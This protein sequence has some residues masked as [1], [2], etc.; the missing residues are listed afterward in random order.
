MSLEVMP[1]ARISGGTKVPVGRE[2]HWSLIGPRCYCLG[3]CIQ[4]HVCLESSS[5]KHI[6]QVIPSMFLLQ[7]CLSSGAVYRPNLPLL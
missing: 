7:G 6:W 1:L 2:G 3:L 4:P 5:K